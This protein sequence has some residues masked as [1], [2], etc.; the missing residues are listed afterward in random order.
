MYLVKTTTKKGKILIHVYIVNENLHN[1]DDICRIKDNF[2]KHFFSTCVLHVD[3]N[4]GGDNSL[5]EGVINIS[6]SLSSWFGM[7]RR[8]NYYFQTGYC[9]EVLA[10][11][12]YIDKSISLLKFSIT[13]HLEVI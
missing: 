3:G 10:S 13:Q 4:F 2:I 5:D 9:L 11:R 12:T 8:N 7:S 1:L 6:L